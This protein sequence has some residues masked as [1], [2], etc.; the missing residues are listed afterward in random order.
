MQLGTLFASQ[1]WE[2]LEEIAYR[3]FAERV[4]S[5]D[6]VYDIGAHIGTYTLIAL[7]R[8]APK[9]RVVAYEP[10]EPTRRH[11]ERHLAWNG[12]AGRVVIRPVCCGPQEGQTEFYYRE[13]DDCAEGM[14]GRVA[15]DGFVTKAVPM[16]SLDQE[17]VRLG[18]VPD[19]IKIDVEGGEWDVL[20]G[21][22]ELLRGHQPDLV[23][24]LHPRA[25]ARLNA[26]PY[27]VLSWLQER[28][29]LTRVLSEDHE[30]HVLA[31]AERKR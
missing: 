20:R 24:S 10:H 29:Y 13:G 6:V 2:T 23:L 19:L 8:S 3:T 9:G 5:G 15:V 4:H 11:L 18:L 22:E 14:N 27:E 16:V 28:G 21:A 25:L 26:A 1:N 30:I 12:G 17:A 31:T 7:Q